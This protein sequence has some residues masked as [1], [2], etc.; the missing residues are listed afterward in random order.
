LT[1]S[2]VP[3]VPPAGL[4]ELPAAEQ[5]AVATATAPMAMRS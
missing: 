4:G 2:I 5:A 3:P 1:P